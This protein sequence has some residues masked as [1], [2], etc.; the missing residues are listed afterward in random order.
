M[1]LQV[2]Q[3][4]K[5][6]GDLTAGPIYVC[7]LTIPR[8]HKLL[9]AW[10]YTQNVV[11]T[12]TVEVRLRKADRMD[13]RGGAEIAELIDNDDLT[14]RSATNARYDFVLLDFAKEIAPAERMYFLSLTGTNAADRFDEP[15]LVVEYE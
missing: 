6:T 5:I 15:L 3:W 12:G 9:R 4:D 2:Q 8:S 7:R 1:A 13:S 10:V 14:A 11:L